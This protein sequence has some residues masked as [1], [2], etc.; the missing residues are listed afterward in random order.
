[1]EALAAHLSL[2]DEHHGN[3]ER[4]RTRR[5][6]QPARARAD[7]ADVRRQYFD[8]H[9][10]RVSGENSKRSGPRGNKQD[11]QNLSAS[12]STTTTCICPPGSRIFA[13]PGKP[14]GA[15]PGHDSAGVTGAPALYQDRNEREHAESGERREELRGER[16]GG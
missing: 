12:A 8:H 16:V 14:G 2:F 7:D 5:N 6:A 3:A 4:R 10:P 13:P 9:Q 1:M 11:A 15:R